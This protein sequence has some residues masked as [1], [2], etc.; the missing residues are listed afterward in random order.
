MVMAFVSYK[1]LCDLSIAIKKK[2]PYKKLGIHRID[3]A[4]W[5][6]RLILGRE[7]VNNFIFDKEVLLSKEIKTAREFLKSADYNF[8]WQERVCRLAERV[9]NL[10]SVNNIDRVFQEMIEEHKIAS[11]FAEIETGTRLYRS[12][13]PFEYVSLETKKKYKPNNFDI[14][15]LTNPII[16]CEVKH[17][18]ESTDLSEATINSTLLSALEQ[19]PKNEFSLVVLRIPF[20][21]IKNPEVKDVFDKVLK[22]IFE[23]EDSKQLLGVLLQWEEQ[24]ELNPG[25]LFLIKYKMINNPNIDNDFSDLFQKLD[26][27]DPKNWISLKK[28]VEEY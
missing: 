11:C 3:L 6:L 28:V 1:H 12:E 22:S 5:V 17:K 23:D 27:P 14:R 4:I 21:W 2:S 10:Q 24:Y 19:V 20:N 7:V 18:L 15:I 25:C 9:F 8:Q 13:I 26:K 16:C